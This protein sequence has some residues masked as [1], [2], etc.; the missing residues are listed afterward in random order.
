MSW[1]KVT[2]P[3]L[4]SPCGSFSAPGSFGRSAASAAP[5]SI[6]PT[7]TAHTLIALVMAS[8]PLGQEELPRELGPLL[9]LELRPDAEDRR[10]AVLEDSPELR[11]HPHRERLRRA[12]EEAGGGGVGDELPQVVRQ[13]RR[14]DLEEPALA[15][16]VRERVGV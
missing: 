13:P 8:S 2:T 4:P 11:A 1:L 3:G 9:A 14:L 6:R 10:A 5:P 7:H 16:R 15:V 12:V